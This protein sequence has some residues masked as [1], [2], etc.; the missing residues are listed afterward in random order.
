MKETKEFLSA[1]EVSEILGISPFT[2]RDWRMNGK[3]PNYFR[4]EGK[5]GRVRYRSADVAEYI[6]QRTIEPER[7]RAEKK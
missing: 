4:S 6:R 1:V 3:G 5:F 2:L 7:E